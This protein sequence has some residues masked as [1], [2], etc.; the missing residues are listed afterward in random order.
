MSLDEK[1]ILETAE[2]IKNGILPKETLK[3]LLGGERL[4]D[5][6]DSKTQQAIF[7][8]IIDN[9]KLHNMTFNGNGLDILDGLLNNR[10]SSNL[11]DFYMIK[12]DYILQLPPE[13]QRNMANS[14]SGGRQDLSLTLQN[15]WG[16]GIRTEACTTKSVDNIPMLQLNIKESEIE[17]Q[18]IIQQLYE[19]SDI[20]GNAFYD[21][22]NK[23]FHINLSGNNLYN[24]LQDGNI[25][26][27]QIGK[28][29]IFEDSIKDSLQFAEEMYT[30]YS[31]NG[32]DTTELRRE[33]LSERKSLEEF[34]NRIENSKKQSKMVEQEQYD[35]TIQPTN[36]ETNLPARQNRFS[37]FFNQ[38]RSR[39]ARQN[40]NTNTN[41][42]RR[43]PFSRR[44]QEESQ[45]DNKNTPEQQTFQPKQKSQ[46][47][48]SWELEPEE[49]ARIQR[50]T[51][52]IAKKFREQEEQQKQVP[53]Q[54]IQQGNM[55][56]GD[57][58]QM[59]QGQIPQQI[60]QQP[61]Q[62]FGGMEL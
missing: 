58:T 28:T 5:I 14:I 55:Q 10:V 27:S 54:E 12:P 34:R 52:E 36:N 38:I 19:Q 9:G 59:Q 22:Q 4:D 40:Y 43:N 42:Q 45:Y 13:Q 8:N 31:Q 30:Y 32:M 57:F 39:F 41:S 51:A 16:K 21:Y 23:D 29:N 61:M 56:Q 11:S 46:E 50:E 33:I 20:N 48:K 24:Y 35:S 18:D 44:K 47:K 6:F 62:D 3:E 26:Q 25:P 49:K 53:T 60:P 17:K 37:R 2:K 7:D 1:Q 15:L